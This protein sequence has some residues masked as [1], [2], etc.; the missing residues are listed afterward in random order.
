MEPIEKLCAG[1]AEWFSDEDP[2]MP[3]IYKD[4]AI[5][6]GVCGECKSIE[7]RANLSRLL[8][9]DVVLDLKTARSRSKSR[10]SG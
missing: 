7:P 8:V 6:F 9:A 4:Q 3:A 5:R 10:A 2:G 1:C